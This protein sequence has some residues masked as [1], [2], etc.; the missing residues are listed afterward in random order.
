MHCVMAATVFA[1]GHPSLSVLCR[2]GTENEEPLCFFVARMPLYAWV[3]HQAVAPVPVKLNH[4]FVC[5]S[6]RA[7]L[8]VRKH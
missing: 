2:E 1:F 4:C 5:C 6:V 3:I 8:Y 7:V